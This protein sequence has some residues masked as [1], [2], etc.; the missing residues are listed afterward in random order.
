MGQRLRILNEVAGYVGW[1][2]VG[3]RWV[4]SDGRE[5]E[6]GPMLPA[7]RSA[8]LVITLRRRWAARCGHCRALVPESRCH[9]RR[10]P[11]QWQE[12]PLRGHP[13]SIEYAAA[14]YRCK[15]C[16]SSCTELL[17][18]A[19]AK[20][21][22][23]RAFQQ[24]LAFE[25]ASAPLSHVAA[26]HE[27]DWH[28]VRRAERAALERWDR[29]TPRPPL[30]HVGLDEK[31][32]GRRNRLAERFVTL[33]S[34]LE[35]GEPV[36]MGRGRDAET[37]KQWLA[38]LTKKQKRRV[39]LVASDMYAPF[40][41]AI[42]EEPDLAHAAYV[43]DPFHIMKRA[44]EALSELRRELFFRGGAELRGL[45][46]GARWLLLRPWA[47]LAE[48]ERKQLRAL[49]VASNG[50]LARAYQTVEALRDALKLRRAAELG[51]AMHHI[52][53]ATARRA[54]QPMRKLHDSLLAHWDG[55]LALVR[56]RPKTGRLEALNNNWEALVRR[57]RGYRDHDH[58]F[59]KLRFLCAN[60]LGTRDGVRRFL[61]LDLPAP[62][63]SKAA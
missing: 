28:A 23:T 8:R 6:V 20:Q 59:L 1:K 47:R 15:Q 55:I 14:R 17:P 46:R 61:G 19:D 24:Q 12:L 54:N 31:W 38:T 52:L 30:R 36:W 63:P 27:V 16:G 48:P 39:R 13:A 62:V 35:T 18:W 57:G 49:F 11:R 58:L 56:L 21:R 25:A 29:S 32:L 26:A 34:D 22:T 10:P 60:P 42:R 51:T 50:K 37:V 4:G 3:C 2:V 40:K 9:E 53:R 33:V 41:K 7:P 43:H 45:G 5:L 44:G